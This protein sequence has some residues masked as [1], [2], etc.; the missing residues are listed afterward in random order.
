MFRSGAE[1]PHAEEERLTKSTT[2]DGIELARCYLHTGNGGL[3][4]RMSSS[5]SR[6]VG[7]ST[8]GEERNVARS[9]KTAGR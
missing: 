5:Q 6:S 9:A 2:H 8:Q 3:S 1:I 4:W 7:L